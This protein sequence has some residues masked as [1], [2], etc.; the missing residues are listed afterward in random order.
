MRKVSWSW[1]GAAN[2]AANSL[3]AVCTFSSI[4]KESLSRYLTNLMHES[5][6]VNGEVFPCT[7]MA[8]KLAKI[9][10]R[11]KI[12]FSL[13]FRAVKFVSDLLVRMFPCCFHASENVVKKWSDGIFKF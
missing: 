1:G 9:D 7:L 6:H 13:S 10:R 2:V 12:I 3:S 11:E 5:L 4:I 8:V